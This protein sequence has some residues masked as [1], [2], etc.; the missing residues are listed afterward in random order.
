MNLSEQLQEQKLEVVEETE[1]NPFLHRSK[2]PSHHSF[3]RGDGIGEGDAGELHLKDTIA[4][5]EG[6]VAVSSAADTLSILTQSMLGT[7]PSAVATA[8][9]AGLFMRVSGAGNGGI[10]GSH[11]GRSRTQIHG[12]INGPPKYTIYIYH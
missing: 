2:V 1:N 10:D 9:A 3:S 7:M 11:T 4:S 5:S 12:S 8:A 6:S